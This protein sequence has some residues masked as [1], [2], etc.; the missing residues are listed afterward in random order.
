MTDYILQITF[1]GGDSSLEELVQSRLFMTGSSGSSSTEA[2]GTATIEAYFESAAAR[3]SAATS[4]GDLPVELH[5]LER[6]RVD[7]LEHYQQSL[8]ALTIGERF[9]VAPDPSLIPASGSR[10]SIIVPQEQAFGTGSHET[11]SLCLELLERIPMRGKVGLDVGSGSG[12]LAIGMHRLGASRVIAFDND[13]DAYG[14]LRDNRRRNGVPEAAMPIFIGGTEALRG[15]SF[16]VITMNILPDVILALLDQVVARLAVDGVLIVSG[17]LTT[18]RDD[19]VDAARRA[20]LRLDDER[21]K[22]EWWAGAFAR[23]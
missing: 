22:G 9:V 13:T 20:G 5:R 1:D 6:P 21:P 7:W 23:T 17:I 11:T 10:Y 4:F 12:I 8:H 3:D 16:D 15:G 2:A 18:R 14:A 19:V